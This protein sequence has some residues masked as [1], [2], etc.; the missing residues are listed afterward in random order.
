MLAL[1]ETSIPLLR[2]YGGVGWMISYYRKPPLVGHLCEFDIIHPPPLVIFGSVPQ[3][4]SAIAVR[5]SL[6]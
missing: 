5:I 6:C 4:T 1:N 3:I 2:S